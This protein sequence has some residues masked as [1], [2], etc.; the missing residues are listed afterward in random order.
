MPSTRPSLVCTF[1][2]LALSIAF[3]RPTRAQTSTAPAAPAATPPPAS[4]NCRQIPVTIIHGPPVTKSSNPPSKDTDA[5]GR[6]VSKQTVTVSAGFTPEQMEDDALNHHVAN[7]FGC[8]AD[9]DCQV[10]TDKYKSDLIPAAE[11]AKF[12]RNKAKYLEIAND[13][14]A[15]CDLKHGRYVEAEQ[16]LHQALTQA[17]IWPGKD[18]SAYPDLWL[19]LSLA[20]LS[21][22]HWQD[23]AAS[24]T[25]AAAIHQTR[26]DNY[27]KI[28]STATDDAIAD[29]MRGQIRREK[30][31]RAT[32]LSFIALC[33]SREGNLDQA[34]NMLEQAYQEAVAGDAPPKDLRDIEN[35]GARLATQTNNSAEAA[36][37]AARADSTP[38]TPAASTPN[39]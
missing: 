12:P 21:Q 26:I 2:I 38:Q 5:N 4:T 37:W 35:F 13:A 24:A 34:A 30:Q 7:S 1:V 14:I 10:T 27:S 6:V 29:R 11:Q 28:L 8:A 3:A 17:E 22:E 15:Q 19:G 16:S 25:Q 36:K 23:A 32:A 39:K 9:L 20:Q 31:Q 33:N 18:D